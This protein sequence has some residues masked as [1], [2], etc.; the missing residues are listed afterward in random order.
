MNETNDEEDMKMK[1]EK[2]E[3]ENSS[4]MTRE[5]IKKKREDEEK[6]P[7]WEEIEK[8][9]CDFV[10]LKRKIKN[11]KIGWLDIMWWEVKEWKGKLPSLQTSLQYG[12][13]TKE[14]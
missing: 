14:P 4:N 2:Q 6:R 12:L 9:E 7:R 8:R 13:F 1:R 11:K 5:K 10:T 3:L